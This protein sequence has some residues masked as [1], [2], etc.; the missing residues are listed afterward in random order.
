VLAALEERFTVLAVDRRGRGGSGDAPEWAIAREFEDVAA[1]AAHAGG[2]ACLL[3]HSF[4]AICALR[5]A[6]LAPALRALVLYE[7]PIGDPV[8]SEALVAGLEELLAAGER[9]RLM[10]RFMAE[11]AGVA[12]DQIEV[13]RSQPAWEGRLAAAHTIP[14]E[15][16]AAGAQRFDPAAFAGLDVPTLVLRGDASPPSMMASAATVAAGLPRGRLVTLA[17]QGHTAM[18]TAT[19]LFV[20]EVLAFLGPLAG[21]PKR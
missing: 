4:G 14:R 21:L 11:V 2:E 15:L 1:V 18:D 16:R 17:G 6:P 8:A 13:M 5:G 19:D 3:G 12:P 7:P 10:S 9:D 20:S